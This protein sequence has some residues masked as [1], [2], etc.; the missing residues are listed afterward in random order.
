[1]TSLLAASLTDP[2]L[3]VGI[4][5]VALAAAGSRFYRVAVIAPGF[6]IGAVAAHELLA[7]ASF[8]IRA[9]AM[10]VAGII[11][12]LVF[13]FTEKTAILA[14][15]VAAGA[16]ATWLVSHHLY[17][18][19]FWA[20]AAG[21]VGGLVVFP[22]LYNRMLPLT[23]SVMGALCIAWAA[24]KPDSLLMIGALTFVGMVLQSIGGRGD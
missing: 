4:A 11:L 14:T 13:H 16:A 15:G 7:S 5:G 17:A 12:G 3:L 10:A 8:G 23:T 18:L 9:G 24:G 1:M 19:P 2:R 22:T 6:A 21:A 20:P